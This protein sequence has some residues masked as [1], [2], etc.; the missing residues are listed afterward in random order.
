MYVSAEILTICD[1]ER[2]RLGTEGVLPDQPGQSLS[3]VLKDKYNLLGQKNAVRGKSRQKQESMRNG[4]Y[5]ME[6][7]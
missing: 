5:K 7:S 3:R 1:K 4:L 2:N 6:C